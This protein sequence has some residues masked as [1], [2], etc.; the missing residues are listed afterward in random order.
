MSPG[1]NIKHAMPSEKSQ[2]RI[3]FMNSICKKYPEKVNLETEE[4]GRKE[5][6]THCLEDRASL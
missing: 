2:D 6:G 3:R 5:M 1:H 4:E